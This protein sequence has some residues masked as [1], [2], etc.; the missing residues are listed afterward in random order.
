M[1]KEKTPYTMFPV[2]DETKICPICKRPFLLSKLKL[3]M[4]DALNQNQKNVFHKVMFCNACQIPFITEEDAR[5]LEQ[6]ED[7]FYIERK[8]FRF[9]MTQS[10]LKKLVHKEAKPIENLPKGRALFMG[11]AREHRCGA[12]ALSEVQYLV[13]GEKDGIITGLKCGECGR[14]LIHPQKAKKIKENYPAYIYCRDNIPWEMLYLK[15]KIL[16]LL[17]INQ[18]QTMSCPNCGKKLK[19]VVYYFK[20]DLNAELRG[21]Q[22]KECVNCKKVF[23]RCTSFEGKPYK[24]YRYSTAFFQEEIYRKN[25]KEVEIQAGDFL[26]RHNVQACVTKKHSMEDIRARVRLVDVK[27]QEFTYDVPAIRCDTCGKLYILESEYQKMREKGVPLCSVVENI[28]W[29]KKPEEQEG[30]SEANPGGSVMYTHGYNVNAYENLSEPQRQHILHVL[31][32]EGI[33]TK[34]EVCSHLDMLIK[35]ASG[36]AKLEKALYKGLADLLYMEQYGKETEVVEAK[37]ITRKV[38]RHET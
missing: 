37:S 30:W 26:T 29:K 27:G 16:Y 7:G 19:K 32:T 8:P 23:G 14:I 31:V 2:L 18:Y 1:P 24:E 21:K 15:Q 3:T 11:D 25:G 36:Q 34:A 17:N 35:R 6:E 22:V 9:G 12:N 38:Y 20:N 28:Y 33:L 10:Y 5:D 4:Y 13:H